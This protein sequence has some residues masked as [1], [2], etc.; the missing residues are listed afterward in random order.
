MRDAVVPRGLR[1]APPC[2]AGISRLC[3][4]TRKIP[5]VQVVQRLQ[6]LLG[7]TIA[8]S[9][10]IDPR[11]INPPRLSR[12]RDLHPRRVQPNKRRTA[13]KYANQYD[14]YQNVA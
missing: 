5:A 7:S 9:A 13:A 3:I 10:K 4:G 2:T 1:V 12:V 6:Q 11:T 14:K 8:Q